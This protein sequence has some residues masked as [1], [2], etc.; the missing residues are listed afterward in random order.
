MRALLWS[1]GFLLFSTGLRRAGKRNLLSLQAS[2]ENWIFSN[3]PEKFSGLRILHISDLH[4]DLCPEVVDRV[5][6]RVSTLDYD[7]TVMT[8]DYQD[9]VRRADLLESQRGLLRIREALAGDIYFVLGNHDDH[10]MLEWGEKEGFI[11]LHDRG[12]EL[13]REGA[14]IF[15]GGLK[16]IS[17]YQMANFLPV[18][19]A[20]STFSLLLSHSPQKAKAAARKGFDFFLSGHTHGGQIC[21]PNGRHLWAA[22]NIPRALCAGRW[23]L[24]A[25]HG[26]TS[27][28]VGGSGLAVRFNCP[29]EIVVHNLFARANEKSGGHTQS[30]RGILPP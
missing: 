14:R 24:G 6:E 22:C 10:S 30:S 4:I 25:M 5:V 13:H 21:L 27:R 1:F 9:G 17:G 12:V 28:G 15:I 29:P 19:A 18:A 7:L 16:Y 11:G 26:Y 2:K 3:L 8:G 20:E 23:R